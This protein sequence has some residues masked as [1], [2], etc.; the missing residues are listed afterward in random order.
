MNSFVDKRFLPVHR[1]PWRLA[2]FLCINK[3]YWHA[4]G[5]NWRYLVVVW[6]HR[7]LERF[8]G[9]HFF[10]CSRNQRSRFVN[11]GTADGISVAC[12][13]FY[14]SVYALFSSL[15][16]YLFSVCWPQFKNGLSSAAR[17]FTPFQGV[18]SLLVNKYSRASLIHWYPVPLMNLMQVTDLLI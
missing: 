8:S 7:R 10:C 11:I 17:A 1:L 13:V 4:D 3:C 14:L 18:C 9:S 15:L 2:S 16:G 5:S 12:Q 6:M